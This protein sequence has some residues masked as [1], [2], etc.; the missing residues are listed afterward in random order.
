MHTILPV[1][2]TGLFGAILGVLHVMSKGNR[3]LRVTLSVA[4]LLSG[5]WLIY[6]AITTRIF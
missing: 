1:I 2:F 5:C 6:S 4:F 3:K